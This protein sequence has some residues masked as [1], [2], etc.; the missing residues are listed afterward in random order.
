MP[1]AQGSTCLDLG[2]AVAYDR[3]M[4]KD[5]M[6]EGL[7]GNLGYHLLKTLEATF[8][9]LEHIPD[10]HPHTSTLYDVQALVNLALYAVRNLDSNDYS[11]DFGELTL[12]ALDDF[13]QKIHPRVQ[14]QAQTRAHIQAEALSE[15]AERMMDEHDG[16]P[17]DDDQDRAIASAWLIEEADRIDQ[18]EEQ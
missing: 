13:A 17:F 2:Y 5:S 9:L 16:L 12:S 7:K 4:T 10:S 3:I 11:S 14:T 6:I 8:P 15:A 1:V 18:G